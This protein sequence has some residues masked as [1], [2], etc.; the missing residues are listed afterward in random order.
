M[1]FDTT[2]VYFIAATHSTI[3]GAI[4]Q[5]LE[6]LNDEDGSFRSASAIVIGNLVEH[7]K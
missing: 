7:G 6:L 2:E 1:P 4:P 5:I 3:K